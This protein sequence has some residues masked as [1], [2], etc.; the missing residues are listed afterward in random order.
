MK[1]GIMTLAFYGSATLP[2]MLQNTG[3][4][5]DKIYLSHSP[6]PWSQYNKNARSIFKS[7]FTA[8]ILSKLPFSEKIVFIEGVWDTD[9]AQR[10]DALQRARKD[11]IDYLI[12]QDADE[13]YMPDQFLLNLK[14]I[15]QNPNFPAYTCPW[16]KFWKSTKYVMEAREHEGKKDQVIS[17]CPNFAVNVNWPGI[18]FNLSRLV[19][20]MDNAY[21]LPGLCLH[22]CWVLSDDQVL[23]KISTWGHSHQ[24]DYK[25]WYKHKWL[26]WT[27][28]MKY[29]GVFSRANYN[30]AVTHSFELPK[31]IED[32]EINGQNYI[33]LNFFE[34][35]KS[36]YMDLTSLIKIRIN[37]RFN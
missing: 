34:K 28:T 36:F 9:E 17:L 10:E 1:F 19:N 27:P 18:H 31:E 23:K 11:G 26:A 5:V 3:P 29:I 25:S 4:Y 15:Q 13:F 33:P 21:K 20:E 16:V 37:E 32:F 30:R 12:I 2:R 7:E 6:V 24:F 8:D 14:T 35:I 22:L